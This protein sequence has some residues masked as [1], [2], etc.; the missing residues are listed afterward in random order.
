MS[1]KILSAKKKEQL[2]K[3]LSAFLGTQG[4]LEANQINSWLP[5]ETVQK[6]NQVLEKNLQDLRPFAD[7]TIKELIDLDAKN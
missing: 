6:L 1:V 7:L 2:S 5:E 4:I 3:A